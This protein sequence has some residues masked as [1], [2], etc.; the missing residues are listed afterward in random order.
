MAEANC[1]NVEMKSL[2][3]VALCLHLDV[4]GNFQ[5]RFE[6]VGKPR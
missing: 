6:D 3:L 1:S 2:L 4:I 5:Q